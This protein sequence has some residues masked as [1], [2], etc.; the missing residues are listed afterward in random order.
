MPKVSGAGRR[1]LAPVADERPAAASSQAIPAVFRRGL[2][3]LLLVAG[4]S[5]LANLDGYGLPA[6]TMLDA[7][8]VAFLV[9]TFTRGKT[10]QTLLLLGL[11]G[12]LAVQVTTVYADNDPIRDFLQAYRW[13][14]YLAVFAVGSGRSWGRVRSL[15]LVTF[16]LIGMA[17]AKAALIFV[18]F[19]PGQRPGLL[20]ENNFEIA[21][22]SGLFAV[23]FTGLRV[24]ARVAGLG[25]LGLLMM[26]AGSRSGAVA[27]AV[28]LVYVLWQVRTTAA[29]KFVATMYAIPAV[30]AVPIL[31]FTGR[32]QSFGN[33]DR[34]RFAE[35][36]LFETQDWSW[37]QWLFGTEAI[38]PLSN[39]AC[40]RMSFYDAL[41]SSAGDGTCYAV[42]LHSFVLRIAFDAGLVGLVAVFA[43]PWFLMRRS[44]V[45]TPLALTLLGVAFTN[46][47]SVS[48]LNNPYVALPILLAILTACRSDDGPDAVDPVSAVGR[49]RVAQRRVVDLRSRTHRGR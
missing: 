9:L 26:L 21:L 3:L 49:D 43:I 1:A 15:Q 35:V 16:A 18:I 30:V 42:I 11:A 36:F 17:L 38:T 29:T 34:V 8:I 7:W 33:L 37:V 31:V 10:E 24:E 41:F 39:Y 32:D 48:G 19:G 12:Y 14:L 23:V 22:F 40:S 45:A 47:L 5:G 6:T 44:G 4:L 2:Y 27:F 25:M 28:V 20:L 46:S 13:V